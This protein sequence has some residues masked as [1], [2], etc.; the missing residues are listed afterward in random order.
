MAICLF[1]ASAAWAEGDAAV[2]ADPSVK[3]GFAKTLAYLFVIVVIALGVIVVC[4]TTSR[5]EHSGSIHTDQEDRL[6][7]EY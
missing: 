2:A 5:D 4:R 1:L 3:G 7:G 6:P